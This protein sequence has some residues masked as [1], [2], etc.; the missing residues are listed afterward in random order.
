LKQAENS[1]VRSAELELELASKI[2]DIQQMDFDA[3]ATFTLS[4][5]FARMIAGWRPEVL[6]RPCRTLLR[7]FEEV[8][9]A[10]TEGPEK[11]TVT[12]AEKTRRLTTIVSVCEVMSKLS[13]MSQVTDAVAT[14]A[15]NAKR[16]CRCLHN[17]TAVQTLFTD[18]EGAGS[19]GAESMADPN[20][21]NLFNNIDREDCADEG[22]TGA[23]C[24]FK[25]GFSRV[26]R[27]LCEREAMFDLLATVDGVISNYTAMFDLLSSV[28]AAEA[29]KSVSGADLK[30]FMS[31]VNVVSKFYNQHKSKA[32]ATAWDSLHK[33]VLSFLNAISQ[34]DEASL[35]KSMGTAMKE[36]SLAECLAY[37]EDKAKAALESSASELKAVIENMSNYA[38][39]MRDGSSWKQGL[40]ENA[41]LAKVLKQ[42]DKLVNGPGQTVKS[43]PERVKKAAN[44][45]VSQSSDTGTT[46]DS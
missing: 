46:W 19:L 2:G 23:I 14:L 30:A 11:A 32:T 9:T 29:K 31:N 37:H 12:A 18:A 8:A 16:V 17:V 33:G 25:S 27:E 44:P 1:F 10:L 3:A 43:I 42:A 24:K 41:T 40:D 15:S 36:H 7:K 26:L 35:V 4:R 39:G 28:D 21:S 5:P 34:S 38:L 20:L 13:K 22:V 6:E 45:V